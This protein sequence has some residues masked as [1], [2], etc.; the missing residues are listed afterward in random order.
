MHKPIIIVQPTAM[1]IC[2]TAPHLQCPTHARA[3]MH[4]KLARVPI[5]TTVYESRKVN[6]HT[7]VSLEKDIR[8]PRRL[9]L[10]H[11]IEETCLLPLDRHIRTG[12]HNRGWLLRIRNSPRTALAHKTSPP[13]VLWIQHIGIQAIHETL[14]LQRGNCQIEGHGFRV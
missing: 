1:S 6:A 13:E 4:L 2:E 11:L 12:G 8:P 10:A 9:N 14:Q 3:L 7:R 5:P